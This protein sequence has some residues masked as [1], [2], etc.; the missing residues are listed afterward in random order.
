MKRYLAIM[1]LLGVFLSQGQAVA[2]TEEQLNAIKRLGQLNG[3]ALH[4]RALGETQ[5]MKR[6]LVRNLP[7]RKELGD[8]FDS[9]SNQSFMK[10]IQDQASCP[11][12]GAFSLEVDEALEHLEKVYSQP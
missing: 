11:S 3:V 5:K 6:E 1:A 12:P 9:E 8:L 10:F 4:C 7:K 2:S